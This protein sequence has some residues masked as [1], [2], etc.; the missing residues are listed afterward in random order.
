[1]NKINSASVSLEPI[2][3]YSIKENFLNNHREHVKI[4]E[5]KHRLV[6]WSL[7]S[8][9]HCYPKIFQSKNIYAKI[10][11]L[12]CFLL[13]SFLTFW[14]VIKGVLDFLEFDVVAKIRV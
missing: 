2:Q 14:L 11:W 7:S 4:T 3:A 5:A 10:L 13:F 9:I 8:N 6:E 1:M 12:I